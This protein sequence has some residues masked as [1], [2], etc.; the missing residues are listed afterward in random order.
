MDSQGTQLNT[1]A[2]GV[3]V[4]I[5]LQSEFEDINHSINKPLYGKRKGALSFAQLPNG[6]ITSVISTGD[7]EESV[8]RIVNVADAALIPTGTK[9][10]RD[11]HK[12]ALM[13]S[14][15]SEQVPSTYFCPV[16]TSAKL[17]DINSSINRTPLTDTRLILCY[18]EDTQEMYYSKGDQPLDPWICFSGVPASNITPTGTLELKPLTQISPNAV[19]Q[20]VTYVSETDLNNANH[21]INQAEYSGKRKGAFLIFPTFDANSAINGLKLGVAS[22]KLPTDNWYII[23]TNTNTS[24]SP[25]TTNF[26]RNFVPVRQ[27]VFTTNGDAVNVSSYNDVRGGVGTNHLFVK[28]NTKVIFE[29][30]TLYLGGGNVVGQYEWTMQIWDGVVTNKLNVSA[31]PVGV[32]TMEYV[33]PADRTVYFSYYNSGLSGSSS[34]IK[35]P[36]I[37]LVPA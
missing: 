20:E 33:V 18:A 35:N 9:Y 12:P 31:L 4:S 3:G 37:L 21:I 10:V 19:L 7:T 28:A 32:H 24:L 29:L 23:G 16:T 34:G 11:P 17:L 26:F 2:L 6:T 1:Q 25:L 15:L 22:G 14:A 30:T 13:P 5:H 27:G 36:K 8:W